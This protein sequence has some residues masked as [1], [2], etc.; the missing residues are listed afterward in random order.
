MERLY[1]WLSDALTYN[2]SS[3][4]PVEPVIENNNNNNNSTAAA[5]IM[6]ETSKIYKMRQA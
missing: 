6:M 1:F 3:Q 5:I 4:T 2:E